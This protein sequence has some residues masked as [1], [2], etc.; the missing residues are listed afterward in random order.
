M[1]RILQFNLAMLCLLASVWGILANEDEKF[2]GNAGIPVDEKSLVEFLN[3]RSR[4]ETDKTQILQ[5]ITKLGDDSFDEREL[6]SAKLCA[7]GMAALP[8]LKKSSDSPDVEIARRSRECIQRIDEGARK[9]ILSSVVRCLGERKSQPALDALIQYA[10]FANEDM[11]FDDLVD[12]LTKCVKENRPMLDHLQKSLGGR[13]DWQ[14]AAA[15]CALIR[16]EPGKLAPFFPSLLT[17][18]NPHA[19]FEIALSLAGMGEAPGILA[20]AQTMEQLDPW[21]FSLVDHLLR[22]TT[23]GE[24]PSPGL[25]PGD[26]QQA[27]L[28]IL[29]SPQW[30]PAPPD[31]AKA[32]SETG[33]TLAV[34][35]DAGKTLYLDR[36][37]R[38][39][40]TIDGLQFPL[41]AQILGN[42]LIL[43]AEHQG[44]RV[45]ERNS[46]NQ[47][48]W[49][50]KIDGPL[51]THR[52]PDGN[53]F[54]ATKNDTSIVDKTGKELFKFQPPNGESIMKASP[55]SNQEICLILSSQQGNSRCVVIDKDNKEKSSFDVDVRTSGGKI[56]ILPNGN[57]IITEVYGNRVVEYTQAGKEVWHL[58]CEQP[59]AAI[60]LPNGNTLI[61]SMT[62]L[63]AFEVNPKGKE[64][65]SFKSDTRVTRAF[66]P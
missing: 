32:A 43:V 58:E 27:W 49:E 13:D 29:S 56:A 3:R 52:F 40:W 8:E 5:L 51:A 34:L 55:M 28:K 53:T 47:I 62:Q 64:V 61:T 31:I 23:T 17:I 16:L 45:T 10:R 24:H 39:L 25:S 26:L 14:K 35:L 2:L 65:W 66:R 22:K 63:R 6:A 33:K 30:K 54:I 21:E 19:R 41:D 11:T 42:D 57:L 38:I 36:N 37:N 18:S 12:A 7:L 4:E 48:L 20:L 60:R 15:G 50:K 1:K 9:K 44:N 59:V 46:K